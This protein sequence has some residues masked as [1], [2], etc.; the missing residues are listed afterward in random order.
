MTRHK[1]F[2][3]E[4]NSTAVFDHTV[5][6]LISTSQ[7]RTGARSLN[8]DGS[9]GITGFRFFTQGVTEYYVGFGVYVGTGLDLGENDVWHF[10]NSAGGTHMKLRIQGL[11]W[12]A[13]RNTGG[14]AVQVAVGSPVIQ[15]E[16]VYVEIRC[17]VANSGGRFVVRING[18]T[19]IDY[20]GDTQTGATDTI[21]QMGNLDPDQFLW[22]DD[23]VVNNTAGTRNNT[24]P[25]D[26][27]IVRMI[28]EAAGDST[29]LAPTGAAANW[30]A[31][32]D[33][34]PDD[35]TT[36][37]SSATSGEKDLYNLSPPPV[38]QSYVALRMWNRAREASTSTRQFRRVV[39][40]AGTEYAGTDQDLTNTYAYYGADILQTSPATGAS[41]T[42]AELQALQGGVE[43]RG[44]GAVAARISQ[45]FYELD[46]VPLEDP[47]DPDPPPEP[48]PSTAPRTDLTPEGVRIGC[49]DYRA[50]IQDRG[51]GTVRAELI[52]SSIHLERRL[53]E[54]SQSSVTVG[55]E[56]LADE[57][58]CHLLSTLIPWRYEL[59]VWRDGNEEWVGP[60][61][62]ATYTHDTVKVIARDLFF[63]FE[64]RELPFDRTFSGTDLATIFLTYATDALSEDN[65][66][67]ISFAPAATGVL[68]DRQVF[69]AQKVRA[70][71]E[72]RE[73]ARSGLDFCAIGRQIRIGGR[74]IPVLPLATL[75]DDSF[76]VSSATVLGM[77]AATRVTVRGSST[78]DRNVPVIGV[79]GGVSADLGL[80]SRVD[81]EGSILDVASATDAAQSRLDLLDPPPVALDGVLT[82]DAPIA[83]FALV[84]G[85]RLDAAVGVGCLQ[86]VQAMRLL[87]VDVDVS[88][89]DAGGL[90]DKVGVSL[91]PLGSVE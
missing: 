56:G 48:E 15:D 90:T 59:S 67:N 87:G 62:E 63:W 26:S 79:A 29:Q 86:V 24:W 58:C 52:W 12:V 31:V 9:G 21:H 10:F 18:V 72:L 2:G 5:G 66:P 69:A 76:D 36:Y 91:E 44:S 8:M 39:K 84:P 14:S 80:V 40:V 20:T 85:A 77:A 22:Y 50:F 82:E 60:I 42:E 64:R 27:H 68:G 71:D 41:W 33:V 32:N 51:G 49:G 47:G 81:D 88:A 54:V 43:I 4:L 28:P 17:F 7:V 70:A 3:F 61:I 65:S 45:V 55:S 78:T 23:V 1:Q 13:Q 16:W 46:Y 38:G 34:T 37:V 89:S 73:L 75:T 6:G 30:D 25:G 74:E 35:D 57:A 53:D 83:F 11:E 19:D